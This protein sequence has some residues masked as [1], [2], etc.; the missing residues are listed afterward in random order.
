MVLILDAREV[1]GVHGVD[2]R[3]VTR[4]LQFHLPAAVRDLQVDGAGRERGYEVADQARGDGRRPLFVDLGTDPGADRDVQVGRDE[5]QPA[6]VRLEENVR[7]DRKRV[8]RGHCP[9]HDR[10]PPLE[11]LLEYLDLHVLTRLCQRRIIVTAAIVRQGERIG[12]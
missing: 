1:L 4:A 2:R 11:I 9:A 6:S 5:L 7:D 3:L 10:E 12:A 8:A